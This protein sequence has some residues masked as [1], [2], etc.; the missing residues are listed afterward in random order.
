MAE[1]ARL[2]RG[3]DFQL[4][5]WIKDNLPNFGSSSSE[6]IAKR[7]TTELG[8]EVNDRHI[9]SRCGSSKDVLFQHRWPNALN[10][11][12]GM[13]GSGGHIPRRLALVIK[14]LNHVV[15]HISANEP[16]FL[17]ED[18]DLWRELVSSVSQL[19]DEPAQSGEQPADE[20]GAK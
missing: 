11:G 6:D 9:L 19:D 17:G 18:A 4:N 7:A 13:A 16:E 10:T 14:V 1:R 2:D 15:V 12:N 8:F 3:Q 5:N 20:A